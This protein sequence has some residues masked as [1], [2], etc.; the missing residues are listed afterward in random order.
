LYLPLTI[1][2]YE[3]NIPV[4]HQGSSAEMNV[5]RTQ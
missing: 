1:D 4:F 2:D 3:K 5:I